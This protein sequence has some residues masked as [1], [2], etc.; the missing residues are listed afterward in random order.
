MT[1]RYPRG[2][3]ET[4]KYD[5][6]RPLPAP[7]ECWFVWREEGFNLEKVRNRVLELSGLWNSLSLS[8]VYVAEPGWSLAAHIPVSNHVPCT[9]NNA[10][11]RGSYSKW[12]KCHLDILQWLSIGISDTR[13]RMSVRVEETLRSHG[14]LA[15]GRII[16]QALSFPSSS[17]HNSTNEPSCFSSLILCHS[18]GFEIW[19]PKLLL[20]PQQIPQQKQL[21]NNLSRMDY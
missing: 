6:E 9:H 14:Y 10:T 11:F 4:I 17:L 5:Q 16:T 12:E 13:A 19:I 1:D 8:Q 2:G 21:D 20:F 18:I 15:A 3:D 7:G